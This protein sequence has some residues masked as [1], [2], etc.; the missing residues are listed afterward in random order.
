MAN[1][2]I[3]KEGMGKQN[4]GSSRLPLRP[5]KVRPNRIARTWSGS[6]LFTLEE[7]LSNG[8]FSF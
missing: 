6:G 2:T 7:S 3:G 4:I 5:E 8:V 1:S